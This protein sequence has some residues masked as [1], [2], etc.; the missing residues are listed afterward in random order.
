MIEKIKSDYFTVL[1]L[2]LLPLLSFIREQCLI[3]G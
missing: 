2:P 1:G 3:A